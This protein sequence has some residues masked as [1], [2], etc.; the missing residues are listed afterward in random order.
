MPVAG[1]GLI[2][3]CLIGM[4]TN[5]DSGQIVAALYSRTTSV[6]R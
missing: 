2:R 3:A 4:W 5:E 6:T 1:V